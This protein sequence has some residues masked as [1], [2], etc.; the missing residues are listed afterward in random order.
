MTPQIA[1]LLK[2]PAQTNEIVALTE[3]CRRLLKF[4]RDEMM[5]YYDEWD[6]ND[7]VYRGERKADAQDVQAQKRG[8]PQKLILPLTFGQV[9]TFV[10]FGSAMY[11]QRDYFY[12]MVSSGAEDE[13]PGQIASAVLEQNLHKNK[14][15]G[16]KLTQFLTDIARFGLGITKESWVHEQT[17]IPQQV[18][19]EE[20]MSEARAGLVQLPAPPMKTVMTPATK[21]LGNKIINISP[22]R[23][24]P[25][26]RLPLTRW[27]EGEYCADE[28]E[29]SKFKLEEL[30]RQGLVAGLENVPFLPDESFSHRR[31]QFLRKDQ[32]V[33]AM[34]LNDPQYYLLTEMQ[35]RL[36]PARTL[37]AP[38]TPLDPLRD[39]ETIYIIWI[40]NDRRIIRISEAG[41]DHEQFGYNA[42]QFL[43]DQNRFV[44]FSLCEVLSA[45]QDTA[46]WFLN[47]RV[48]SVRK[49]IFNQ[50]AVDPAAIEMDD[51]I[52][53]SPVIRLKSGRAGSGIDTWIKQLPIQDVTANHLTD[54]EVLMTMGKEASGI[55]ENLLGQFSSGRRSAK[56]AANVANFAASRLKVIFASIW[57]SGLAPM[58]EKMLA[59]L[60]QGLDEQTMVRV[61]G[62]I[63]TQEAATVP[64]IPGLVPPLYR[65]I[66]VSKA[67]LVGNYDF[68]AFD[69]TLPTQRQSIAAIQQEILAT[70]SKDPRMVLISQL[71]PALLFADMLANLGVR[72]VQ[73]F[74]LTPERLQQ[75]IGMV[76]APTNAGGPGNPP[77]GGRGPQPNRGR[78]N[79][80]A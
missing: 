51:I 13:K 34:S 57:E 2:S 29:E 32:A 35:I 48:T 53:R 7:M 56:E 80:G 12:E 60:R 36:N 8:E 4:S 5:K 31:L 1:E 50:L 55:N 59:N 15:R 6:R 44:N 64:D 27:T 71:D 9:Q 52:K 42:A 18:V 40:A 61:Y 3:R 67:D 24:F 22:Y 17:V 25:D 69:G 54:V 38:N 45:C 62:Q 10:A 72:N 41:Y 43:D 20:K 37:I 76:S 66:G 39:A 73:R 30:T 19:D 68:A 79:P 26:V 23:W 11:N 33:S 47:S 46:T 75:L 70:M 16:T 65:L 77:S 21:Y 74:K 78:P 14:F 28:I 49:T 63:N 58:G